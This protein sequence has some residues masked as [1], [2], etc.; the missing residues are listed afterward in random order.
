MGESMRGRSLSLHFLTSISLLFFRF[1][2]LF[3]QLIIHALFFSSTE[4]RH[5][6]ILSRARAHMGDDYQIADGRSLEQKR[7]DD[8]TGEK[9]RQMNIILIHPISYELSKYSS[10]CLSFS[11]VSSSALF[12]SRV[13]P[14][15]IS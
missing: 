9:D 1:S 13:L 2:Y 10:V 12:C 14:S 11:P 3:S 8:E 5:S 4:G 15:A 6:S 7:A